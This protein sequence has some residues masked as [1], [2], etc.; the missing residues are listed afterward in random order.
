V[1]TAIQPDSPFYPAEEYH[2]QFYRKNPQ[3][4]EAYR[5]GCRRD[6]RL[7]ELWGDLAAPKEASR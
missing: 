4:Y 3:R 1:V 7:Q 2:Q 6:A 5:I